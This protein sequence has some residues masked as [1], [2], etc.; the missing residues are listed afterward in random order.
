MGS[1]IPLAVGFALVLA[2]ACSAAPAHDRAAPEDWNL[3]RCAPIP[4]PDS[5]TPQVPEAVAGAA[6][7]FGQGGADLTIVMPDRNGGDYDHRALLGMVRLIRAKTPRAT[8]VSAAELTSELRAR[9]VLVVGTLAENAFA[10]TAL[11]DKAT[12]FLTGIAAGGYHLQA[13]D[14]PDRTGRKIILALGADAAGA[15]AVAGVLAYSIHPDQTRLT[16]LQPWPVALPTGIYWPSFEA[17]CASRDDTLALPAAPSPAPV[18]PRIP[19]G[20]RIWGSPMPTLGSFQRLVRTLRTLGVNTIAIQG[21]GWPDLPDAAERYRA[22]VEA[23]W[24][25]GI[26]TIIYVGNEMAAHRPFP[27]PENHRAVVMAT[28]DLP[29]LLEWHLYNQL[30]AEL[31]A[32]EHRLVEEQM[33]WLKRVSSKR[34]GVEIV[35]GHDTATIPTNKVQLIEDLKRWGMDVVAHDDAP[36]GG[37]SKKHDLSV[38]ERRL[39]E[40]ARFNLPMEAV[41]QAHV[42]FLEPTLPTAAEVRNQF[43][44]AAAGGARGFLCEAAYLFTHLSVRGLL[45]WDLRPLPDGR[46]DEI[47]RLSQVARALEPVLAD[48]PPLPD[49]ELAALG[50]EL[51]RGSS[52]VALRVR[53]GPTGQLYLLVIN[54]SAEAITRVTIA[55]QKAAF[56]VRE[57]T[58]GNTLRATSPHRVSLELTP[59]DGACIQLSETKS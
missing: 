37:W 59:G 36:I 14:N 31:T 34:V 40:L 29:G 58:P 7:E 45:S 41:L 28:K 20:V 39:R 21:G 52:G 6:I 2:S 4:F 1:R 22:A 3:W 12:A 33:R 25:E 15:W 49:S 35:W 55:M 13:I 38:W 56:T 8:V 16:P 42:P 26:F 19:F 54:E 11:G 46:C 17:W 44:W 53:R 24:R 50:L 5:I 18:A 48:A 43:W 23:A 9:H 32:D 27:L 47:R 51:D 10:R 30:S 57:L